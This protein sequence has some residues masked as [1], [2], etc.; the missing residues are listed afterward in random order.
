M[1]KSK[2]I[3][4]LNTLSTEEMRWLSKFVSSPY[5]NSNV[6][7]VRLFEYLKKLYPVFSD[8]KLKEKVVFA[9]VFGREKFDI[10]RLRVVSSRLFA[11]I[12]QFLVAEN[13]KRDSFE[14]QQIL[15]EEYGHRN[16]YAFFE[17]GIKKINENL[18][19][20]AY[21][22]SSYFHRKMLVNRRYYEHPTTNRQNAAGL[23]ALTDCM[24]ALDGYLLLSKL[25]LSLGVQS[26]QANLKQ[27]YTI[28]L[29][30]EIEQESQFSFS[31]VPAV[32]LYRNVLILQREDDDDLFEETRTILQEKSEALSQTDKRNIILLLT[33][34]C[35]KRESTGGV[36]FARRRFDLRRFALDNDCIIESGE[37]PENTFWNMVVEGA[38]LGEYGWADNFITNYQKYLNDVIK[39]DIVIRCQ[40]LLNFYKRNY[41]TVIG[42]LNQYNP[43]AF[44]QKLSMRILLIRTYFMLFLE[45]K[46]YEDVLLSQLDA[47][48]KFIRREK[49]IVTNRKKGYLK[50]ISLVKRLTL[51]KDSKVNLL[52]LQSEVTSSTFIQLRYWLLEIIKSLLAGRNLNN[53]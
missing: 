44:H 21:Q 24:D 32:I 33:N 34:Y 17:K 6:H 36:G 15:T 26:R 12:E 48:E 22:D 53:D 38:K 46:N 11:V 25:E 37:I 5:Y 47:F 2:L 27:N 20:Q 28:R 1:E 18:D 49:M 30:K 41:L 16:L 9:E 29:L 19:E 50:F 40:A 45:D 39:I 14:F 3:L 51:E 42:L 52:Q 23:Q 31:N 13:M 4:V 8:K 10:K 7:V 43:S 35:T